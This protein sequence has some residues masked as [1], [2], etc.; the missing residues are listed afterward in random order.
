MT[1]HMTGI[2]LP[3]MWHSTCHLHSSTGDRFK[4]EM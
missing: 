1:Q 4:S 2:Y 3:Y